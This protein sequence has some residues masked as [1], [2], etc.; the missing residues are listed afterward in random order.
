MSVDVVL[1]KLRA[2]SVGDK[3][4][5]LEPELGKPVEGL[6]EV[7]TFAG[8]S[9]GM[10]RDD[11][12]GGKAKL[13]LLEEASGY[14]ML[15]LLEEASGNAMLLL[16]EEA[17]GYAMLLLLEEASGYAKLLLLEEASGYAMLLLLEEASGYAMLLL[18]EEAS[19]YAKLLRE[20]D[21]DAAALFNASAAACSDM[22]ML[23][24]LKSGWLAEAE[25]LP[26][27]S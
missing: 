7:S 19:G 13:L 5:C 24:L 16:L 20:P 6:A 14:A 17:S 18:L 10:D 25:L 11:P 4:S 12:A 1:S 21:S 22:A 3:L 27:G 2:W 23:T 26:E 15:L 8:L 9:S